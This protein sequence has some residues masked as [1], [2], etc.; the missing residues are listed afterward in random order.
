M[1][2]PKPHRNGESHEQTERSRTRDTPTNPIESDTSEWPGVEVESHD[3]GGR[4]FT[5]DGREVGHVHRGRLIDI[6]F[7]K[8]IRDILIEE[9]RAEK[10]HVYPDSGWV[11]YCVRSDEDIDGALWL[12]RIS[13]LYHLI[14]MRK[15]EKDHSAEDAVNIDAV[16]AELDLSDALEHVFSERR[17][18][19]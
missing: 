1:V 18:V 15:R 9:E 2:P 14:A 11:S 16:L 8:R 4:E 17:T 3:R 19:E 13:Y 12:L 6:P 7:A 5:L 10:H